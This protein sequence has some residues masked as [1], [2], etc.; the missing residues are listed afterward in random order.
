M[1]TTS[2]TLL[3]ATVLAAGIASLPGLYAQVTVVEFGGDDLASQ[4]N[5]D[6]DISTSIGVTP[7]G[8]ANGGSETTFS[9]EKVDVF[10]TNG[11]VSTLT[12]TGTLIASSSGFKFSAA[13]PLAEGVTGQEVVS[14]GCEFIDQDTG[15]CSIAVIEEAEGLTTTVEVSTTTGTPVLVT[16]PAIASADASGGGAASFTGKNVIGIIGTIVTGILLGSLQVF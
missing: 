6:G 14:W 16:L 7:I 12:A 9:Y 13:V 4:Q 10:S 11:V 8:T 15:R 2:S 5:S 1:R 3:S